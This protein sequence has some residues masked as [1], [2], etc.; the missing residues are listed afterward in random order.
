MSGGKSAAAPRRRQ[1]RPRRRRAR[2]LRSQPSHWLRSLRAPAAVPGIGPKTATA[3]VTSP[4]ILMLRDHDELTSHCSVAP[5]D[6]RSST[7][8]QSTSPQRG[9]D[10]PLKN[11]LMLS[12]PL[13]ERTTGSQST[14]TSTGR[15]G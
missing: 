4:G 11:L 15:G 12:C 6:S 13:S 1:D 5:T 3:L 8:I 7:S 10:N 2:R 14:A 9:D